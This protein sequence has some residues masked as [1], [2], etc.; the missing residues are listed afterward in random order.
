MNGKVQMSSFQTK[1]LRNV[2]L[3]DGTGALPIAC[4]VLIE[5]DRISKIESQLE[6]SAYPLS[7][8]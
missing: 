5:G 8:F 3:I 6:I 4:D 2:V 1:L 7:E